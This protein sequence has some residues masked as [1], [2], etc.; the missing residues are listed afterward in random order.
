[1]ILG[2]IFGKCYKEKA[3]RRFELLYN[4]LCV[5]CIVALC[6]LCLID[7]LECILLLPLTNSCNDAIQVFKKPPECGWFSN[8]R[9]WHC[10]GTYLGCHTIKIHRRL[11]QLE[12]SLEGSL[13]IVSFVWLILMGVSRVSFV[14][15]TFQF[16][17]KER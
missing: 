4:Y 15:F 10:K 17:N 5:S 8:R 9:M 7:Q 11:S 1:M 3:L 14:S 2:F 16:T 6:T 13:H 12:G